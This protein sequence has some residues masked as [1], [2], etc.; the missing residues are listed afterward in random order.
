MPGIGFVADALDEVE[1]FG[2]S[3]EDD[4]LGDV[5]HVDLLVL[6]GEPDGGD[7]LHAHLS[8]YV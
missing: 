1:R 7:L 8:H 6:L 2:V 5:L 3:G 4:G